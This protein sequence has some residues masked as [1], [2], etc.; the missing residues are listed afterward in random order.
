M[1]HGQLAEHQYHISERSTMLCKKQT[2]KTHQPCAFAREPWCRISFHIFHR[3]I[4]SLHIHGQSWYAHGGTKA[5]WMTYYRKHT[6]W[7]DRTKKNNL[8][9]VHFRWYQEAV[10]KW[11]EHTQGKG[12]KC[13]Y[14]V[15]S[16]KMPLSS[17]CHWNQIT[18]FKWVLYSCAYIATCCFLK[19]RSAATSRLLPALHTD[20]KY[21]DGM[22]RDVEEYCLNLGS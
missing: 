10:T 22:S 9:K 12:C 7:V 6:E 2:A 4:F 17:F 11:N 16:I 1:L 3:R 14:T 19:S 5:S 13:M 18:R 8:N 21:I 20:T 15:T